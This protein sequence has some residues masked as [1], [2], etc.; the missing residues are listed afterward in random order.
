MNLRTRNLYLT[1]AFIISDNIRMTLKTPI[2]QSCKIQKPKSQIGKQ[3]LN[4]D[5]IMKCVNPRKHV[6][7]CELDAD[8]KN[9]VVLQ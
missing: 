9:G 4:R 2:S 3:A 6:S 5:T 7:V 8:L 1:S